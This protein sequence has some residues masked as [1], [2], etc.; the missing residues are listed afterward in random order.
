ME[1]QAKALARLKF[2]AR[3][4]EYKEWAEFRKEMEAEAESIRH[5]LT[6]PEVDRDTTQFERGKYF[7]IMQLMFLEDSVQNLIA[8]AEENMER[9]SADS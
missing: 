1:E 7:Q 9:I 4:F 3:L 2:M 6:Y 5:T 8:E